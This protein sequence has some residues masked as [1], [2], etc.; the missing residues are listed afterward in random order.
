M[1]SERRPAVVSVWES[2]F[3]LPGLKLANPGG[4]CG[5]IHGFL[6]SSQHHL[7][8]RKL[9]ASGLVHRLLSLLFCNILASE[10]EDPQGGVSSHVKD[11]LPPVSQ[12]CN[13]PTSSLST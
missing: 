5:H 1:Y 6:T 2:L 11:L 9:S 7:Q 3:P 10:W 13:N 12:H 8:G 4:G